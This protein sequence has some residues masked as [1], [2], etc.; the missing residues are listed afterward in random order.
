MMKIKI[1]IV[2]GSV[3]PETD[4]RLEGGAMVCYSRAIHRNASGDIEKI[5]EWEPLSKIT[6]WTD[7]YGLRSFDDVAKM[8]IP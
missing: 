1:D 3:T 2:M 4:Y 6:N 5:T 8:P 7:V